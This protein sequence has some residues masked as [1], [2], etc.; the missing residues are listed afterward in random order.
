MAILH[1]V[2][3]NVGYS[4]IQ[5]LWDVNISIP[6]AAITALIGSNGAGK[7]TLI[8]TLSGIIKPYS[9]KIFFKNIDITALPSH[10]IRS[11]GLSVVPEG[12]RLFPNLTVKENLLMGA[13]TIK[14]SKKLSE[15]IAWV[16]DLFPILK[17]RS[18]QPARQLSGGE[19]QMLAIAR[20]LVSNS[21]LL[22]IDEPSL[23]LAPKLV[24][25]IFSKLQELKEQGFTIFVVDQFV[26]RAL[27]I[28]D[29]AYVME[30][31]RIVLSG[32]REEIQNNTKLKKYYI[33][34]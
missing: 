5:V 12:R 28:C 22:I 15:R 32:T 30:N 7:S 18:S 13:Y 4:R 31:G 9:G 27:N 25:L 34:L 21:D 6:E 23:G 3:L 8:K 10:K 19:A 1:T 20:A 11:L 24:D 26:E 29:H 14:D 16:E 33:G 17:E 2:N